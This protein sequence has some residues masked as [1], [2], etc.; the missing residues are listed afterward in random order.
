MPDIFENTEGLKFS[1]KRVN[2]RYEVLVPSFMDVHDWWGNWEPERFL[3]ME[4]NLKPGMV[5]YE[6]GAF[7]GWQ[8]AIISRFVGGGDNMILVEPVTENWGNIKATWEANCLPAPRASYCGLIGPS[9]PDLSG[10]EDK[11][12]P[13]VSLGWPTGPD[14][15]KAIAVTKFKHISENAHDT[16]SLP[17]DM[18]I[19]EEPDAINIDVEGAELIVL[20]SGRLFLQEHNPLVWV[21]VHPEFM[22]DRYDHLPNDVPLFMKSLGYESEFLGEDHERHYLFRRKP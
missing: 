22:R 10:F 2:G 12:V 15:S 19:M 17:L 7:D 16:P 1:R 21:S 20:E 8:S 18:L 13:Q 3:S 5:L 14:Y 6:I 4:Q 11:L 9:N